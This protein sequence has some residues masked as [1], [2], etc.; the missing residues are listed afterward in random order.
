MCEI[1]D[2]KSFK[3]KSVA[4]SKSL[5]NENNITFIEAGTILDYYKNNY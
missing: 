3:E 4:N 2:N 1:L 5:A